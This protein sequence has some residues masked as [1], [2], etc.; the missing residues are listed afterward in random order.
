VRVAVVGGGIF[1]LASSLELARRG[2]AVVAFEQGAIPNPLASSTDVSKT[3]Q[4][5]YGGRAHYVELAERADLGWRAWR[6]RLDGPDFYHEI[7]HV[8]VTRGWDPGHRGYDSAAALGIR[9]LALAEARARFPQFSIGPDDTVFF[10]AWGGYLVSAAAVAGMA[11]LAREDGADL[12][13]NCPVRAIDETSSGVQLATDGDTSSFD[14]VVVAA[15]VWTSRL[16]PAVRVAPTRQ[17]MAFFRPA[18]SD[19]HRPGPMP[20]FAVDVPGDAWY[21]HPLA[22]GRVKVADNALGPPAEPDSDREAGPGFEERARAFVKRWMPGLAAGALVGSRSC[23]YENTPDGDFV[24][25]HVPR[26]DRVLVASGGSGHGFK[27]G[28]AIGPLVADALEGKAN[29][30]GAHFRLGRRFA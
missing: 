24:I 6:R 15:G 2:H 8:F 29:A 1:G 13:Q 11:R 12:R 25:D 17:S 5:L 21:G 27:F 20:V 3:I 23:M 16:V 7:G 19:I 30:F 28:A 26:S 4:R 14:H 22:D 18:R 10:D 9:P